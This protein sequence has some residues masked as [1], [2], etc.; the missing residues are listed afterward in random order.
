LLLT[1][2]LPGPEGLSIEVKK[3]NFTTKSTK[4]TKKE[5]E[6]QSFRAFASLH[7]FV[8]FVSSWF[9]FLEVYSKRVDH[10][11]FGSEVISLGVLPSSSGEAAAVR[12]P[13]QACCNT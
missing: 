6:T 12:N 7:L 9:Y 13:P 5:R 1:V 8:F 10:L 2:C 3:K 11:G 4:S